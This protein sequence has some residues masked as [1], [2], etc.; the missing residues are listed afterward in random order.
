MHLANAGGDHCTRTAGVLGTGL[1][2]L[3][4]ELTLYGKMP[5]ELPPFPLEMR[6]SVLSDSLRA[7]LSADAAEKLIGSSNLETAMALTVGIPGLL[8]LLTLSTLHAQKEVPFRD[9]D[10][11]VR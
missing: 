2:S 1:S 8:H 11:N 4:L 5:I 6:K 3:R 7:F 10:A 9:G